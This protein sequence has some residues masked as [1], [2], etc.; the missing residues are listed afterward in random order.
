MDM[1]VW[2]M[3]VY[4]LAYVCGCMGQRI[5]IILIVLH[6]I[7]DGISHQELIGTH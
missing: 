6:I 5:M 7:C 1:Y 2:Y 4:L 3:H